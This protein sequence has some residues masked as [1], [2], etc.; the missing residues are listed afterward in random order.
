MRVLASVGHIVV[1]RFIAPRAPVLVH[2]GHVYSKV[3]EWGDFS[4]VALL[5]FLCLSISLLACLS[6]CGSKWVF[7]PLRRQGDY[8]YGRRFIFC[9]TF[10]PNLR[11]FQSHPATVA[12]PIIAPSPVTPATTSSAVAAV[13]ISSALPHPAPKF[14]TFHRCPLLF[15]RPILR[16][17][18]RSILRPFPLL[19]YEIYSWFVGKSNMRHTKIALSLERLMPSVR[20]LWN[21]LFLSRSLLNLIRMPN[22]DIY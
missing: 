17:L 21:S 16:L 9:R 10:S 2:P 13:V 7:W 22:G 5:L 3:A 20:W 12:P 18:I 15:L 6:C 4:Y 1:P 14:L 19:H 8:C 11:S